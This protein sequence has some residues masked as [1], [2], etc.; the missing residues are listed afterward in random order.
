MSWIW[1]HLKSFFL[2]KCKGNIIKG[3]TISIPGVIFIPFKLFVSFQ[4]NFSSLSAPDLS[5]WKFGHLLTTFNQR[6]FSNLNEE[7]YGKKCVKSAILKCFFQNFMHVWFS[8]Q[9][10]GF[11]SRSRRWNFHNDHHNTILRHHC[12]VFTQ[13]TWRWKLFGSLSVAKLAQIIVT[14]G[15]SVPVNCC[16]HWYIHSISEILITVCSAIITV[17]TTSWLCRC[18]ANVP[19]HVF[20]NRDC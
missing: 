7:S 1:A 4:R 9:R 14:E 17:K 10:S 11:E 6:N 16:S 19:Q 12:Q 20:T 15:L 3:I 5:L 8:P 2:K 13:A 18:Y